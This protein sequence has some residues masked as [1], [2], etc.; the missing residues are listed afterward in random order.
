MLEKTMNKPT[1]FIV[2]HHFSYFTSIV[3]YFALITNQP[4]RG[5]PWSNASPLRP[6]A[7]PSWWSGWRQPFLH[8]EVGWHESDRFWK[9]FGHAALYCHI[10]RITRI[11]WLLKRFIAWFSGLITW[12]KR[13]VNWAPGRHLQSVSSQ[14]GAIID[15]S[16]LVFLNY[17]VINQFIN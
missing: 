1:M 12:I 16:T 3:G 4:R 5:S 6:H 13:T 11:F 9:W 14:F 7:P 15:E 8:V 2:Y 10:S 17:G